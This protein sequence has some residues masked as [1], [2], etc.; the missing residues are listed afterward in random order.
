[1]YKAL[2]YFTCIPFNCFRYI[3]SFKINTDLIS[4]LHK[5]I[6]RMM[7]CDVLCI[8]SCFC[9]LNSSLCS[10]CWQPNKRRN[11][12]EAFPYHLFSF[13]L[14]TISLLN[15]WISHRALQFCSLLS[16]SIFAIQHCSAPQEKKILEK[17]KPN[18]PPPKKRNEN[19]LDKQKRQKS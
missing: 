18:Q 13:V 17:L 5:V 6:T 15:F 11:D 1:M 19:V 12:D 9:N 7:W 3:L 14:N 4:G 10:Q 8:I 2:I 16:S